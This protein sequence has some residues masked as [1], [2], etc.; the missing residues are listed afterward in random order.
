[1][2][3]GSGLPLRAP[4]VAGPAYSTNSSALVRLSPS[5]SALEFATYLDDYGIP[6][7]AM[8]ADGSL[9]A[10]VSPM[11]SGVP[12]EVLCIPATGAGGVSLDGIANAFSGD[13]GAVVFGGLYSLTGSGFQAPA[14]DLGL[15]AAQDLPTRL[16]GLE[17]WFDG[18]PAAIL[19]TGPGKVIVVPPTPGAAREGRPAHD[20]VPGFTAIRVVAQDLQSN[21]V[22]MPVAASL[23]GLLTPRSSTRSR[24][25]I[26]MATYTMRTAR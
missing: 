12:A 16:G 15:N 26:P 10:G 23:P 18:V 17:V 2:A 25:P 8:A 4:L 20:T 14:I 22:W 19:A 3:T 11:A 24:P 21:V 1:M 5:G 7:I 13:P 6:G 9:L